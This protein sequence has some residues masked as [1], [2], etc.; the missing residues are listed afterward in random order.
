MN[1]EKIAEIQIQICQIFIANKINLDMIYYILGT[2][3]CQFA[4][5]VNKDMSATLQDIELM[6]KLL[7]KPIEAIDE[8]TL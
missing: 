1:P 5:I 7:P 8:H 4:S 6:Y 2:Q 3:F